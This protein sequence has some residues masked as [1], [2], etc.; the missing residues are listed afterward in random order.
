MW[1]AGLVAQEALVAVQSEDSLRVLMELQDKELLEDLI[2]ATATL[3]VVVAEQ[4]LL[5][6]RQMMVA[7][8]ARDHLL[9]LHLA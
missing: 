2:V 7:L 3:A 9:V 8:V 1:Q 6:Q 4:V 5:D